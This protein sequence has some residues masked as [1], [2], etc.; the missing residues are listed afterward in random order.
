VAWQGFWEVEQGIANK[1][2]ANNDDNCGSYSEGIHLQGTLGVPASGLLLVSLMGRQWGWL[3]LVS[4]GAL[5]C[6]DDDDYYYNDEGSNMAKSPGGILEVEASGLV[7][8]QLMH[9]LGSRLEL[10]SLGALFCHDDDD[11]DDDVDD[12]SDM[13]KSPEGI[14]EVEVLVLVLEKLMWWA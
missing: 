7:L 9:H 6:H 1:P 12:D 3:E 2:V 5:V 10:V 13:A 14:L 11:D 8:E 4:L